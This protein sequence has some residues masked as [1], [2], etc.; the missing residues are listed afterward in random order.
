M[1]LDI[2]VQALLVRARDLYPENL[3][4]SHQLARMTGPVRVAV[5]GKPNTGKSTLLDALTG[6]DGFQFVVDSPDAV[7]YLMRHV[8]ATDVSALEAAQDQAVARATRMNT[9]AVLAHA[10]EIGAGRLDAMISARQIARR[11]AA[12]ERLRGLCQTV[13]PVAGLLA[14]TASTLRPDEFD[15]LAR[16]AGLPRAEVDPW[17]LSADRARTLSIP[18]ALVDRLGMF[19]IRLGVT[20]VRGGFGEPRL[21]AAELVRRSGLDDLRDQLT[22]HFGARARLLKARSG[23]ITLDRALPRDDRTVTLLVDVERLIA[24]AHEFAE[25]RLLDAL[26]AGSIQVPDG[27]QA[28]VERLLGAHG[29][30]VGSRLGLPDN[31]KAQRDAALA[32]LGDWQRRAENPLSSRQFAHAARVIVRTCEGLLSE[33]AG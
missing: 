22:V 6:T 18:D 10:D 25:V 21:L 27:I 19:G 3:E 29:V 24:G 8:H 5:D 1:R 17:L 12:D 26:R 31:T 13:V 16:L 33:L 23:L 4:I 14:R 2:E 7:I 32:T 15:V 11:Y 28:D 20:L 9:V 30:T